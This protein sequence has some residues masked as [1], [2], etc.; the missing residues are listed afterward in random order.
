MQRKS[1]RKVQK[2]NDSSEEQETK[3]TEEGKEEEPIDDGEL[4]EI[5][6][7]EDELTRTRES[8]A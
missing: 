4:L 1:I 8:S 2:K 3:S 6:L 5:N 7:P